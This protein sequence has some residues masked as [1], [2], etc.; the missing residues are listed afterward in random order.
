MLRY[1]KK[2]L[3][4]AAMALICAAVASDT[5]V[6][7]LQ[8]YLLTNSALAAEDVPVLDADGNGILNAA[9]LSLYKRR[10]LKADAQPAVP[11][12]SRTAGFYDDAFELGLTAPEGCRILYTTDGSDPRDSD[13]AA[14]YNTALHI[15]DNTAEPNRL[16][17][18]G[19]ISSVTDYVPDHPV[20]KGIIIRA[21]CQDA[22][23][24]FGE[25]VTNG[26]YIGKTTPFYKSLR[27][28]SITTAPDALFD[29]ESGIYLQKNCMNKGREWE[30]PA[31]IQVYE[32]GAAVYSEDVGVRIAG[33]W[34]RNYPQKSLTFYARS[35]YGASKMRYDFFGGG[36]KDC[37]D[38]RITEYDKVTL[39]NGGDGYDAVRFRDDLNA[40]L[41]DGLQI[42]TQ[43][44]YDYVAFIDGEF[45]G[46]YSMQEKL[47]DDYLA[48]HYHIPKKNITTIKNTLGE[49]DEAVYQ[50]YFDFY[51][52]AKGADFTD[53][54]NYSRFCEMI[55]VQSMIDWIAAES[56]ICNWDSLIHVNNTMIWRANK[57]DASNLY[58]DGRWRFLLYDTEYSSG[59]LDTSANYGYLC[60]MDRSG[61]PN[62]FGTLFY[63]LLNNASFAEQFRA[64]YEEALQEHF[65]AERAN[66]QIDRYMERL[67][68]VYLATSDRFGI[69]IDAEKQ[70]VLTNAVRDFWARRAAYAAADLEACLREY[71][72]S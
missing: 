63:R 32:D 30:I 68:A 50:S 36:A 58:A 31:H 64:S 13:T 8:N 72:G 34:S 56:I 59:F 22:E 43:A 2:R 21:V 23:G 42:G 19:G 53:A 4:P 47:G 10:L 69:G 26:Y 39:R 12:F 67:S 46:Y 41:A 17:A 7:Q 61:E 25:V 24:R 16:S 60:N 9:D 65:T 20:D 51:D 54:G 70:T 40:Y 18:I 48:S 6:P 5:A 14:F 49:G 45:W 38:S 37:R 15:Y 27:V 57:T 3:L 1:T 28:I 44:K 29:P 55:D 66:A 33:N 35:E 71:A 11:F 62:S 52:W